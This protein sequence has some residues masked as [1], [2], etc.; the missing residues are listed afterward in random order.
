MGYSVGSD[1]LRSIVT[2]P[3]N[4]E[5]GGGGGQLVDGDEPVDQAIKTTNLN[6]L[7]WCA[8]LTIYCVNRTISV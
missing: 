3:N 5:K 8:V 7:Q 6:I 2:C 4:L 1:E